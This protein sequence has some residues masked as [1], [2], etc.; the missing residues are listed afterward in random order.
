MRVQSW[1]LACYGLWQ[2]TDQGEKLGTEILALETIQLCPS[3]L[4]PISTDSLLEIWDCLP[5]AVPS[6][7]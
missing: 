6:I 4:K 1:K 7:A 5:I 2:L 3:E